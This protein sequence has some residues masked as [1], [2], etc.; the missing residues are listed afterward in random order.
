MSDVV[1]VSAGIGGGHD[2]V[3]T[4]L[5]RRLRLR[6]MSTQVLDFVDLLPA[7]LG[8]AARELYRTQIT[9]VPRTWAWVYRSFDRTRRSRLAD[10]LVTMA[11]RALHDAIGAD[12]RVVVSTYP[13]AGRA[14]GRL[15]A[16]GRLRAPAVA[17]LTDMAVHRLWVADGV[18]AHIAIHPAP[19]RQA[20]VL[21]AVGTVVAAPAVRPAA[22]RVPAAEKAALRAR[23]GLPGQVRLALVV[24]GSWGVGDLRRT[25]EDVAATGQAVPVVVCGDNARLRARLEAG[26]TGHVVGWTDDF[27]DLIAAADVVVQNAGGLTSLETLACGVPLVSYRCVPG[28]GLANSQVLAAAGLAPLVTG[29]EDL[30]AVIAGPPSTTA[31]VGRL[32]DAPDPADVLMA[33]ASRTAATWKAG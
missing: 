12:A 14:L 32:F 4:E 16:T 1:L 15:R 13:L 19:A 7:A 3:A 6:G 18:D 5:S 26:G 33:V 20:D 21:G 25:V 10:A 2:G 17:Y 22:R 29:V 24:G 11:S 8:P 23:S 27:C 9:T 28:H 31:A 30:R